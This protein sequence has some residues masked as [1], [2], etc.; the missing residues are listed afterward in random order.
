PS[1]ANLAE[2]SFAPTSAARLTDAPVRSATA[3]TDAT[4]RIR[5]PIDQV[6][7]PH[8]PQRLGSLRSGEERVK[9]ILRAEADGGG[10]RK[11]WLRLGLGDRRPS[12]VVARESR[13]VDGDA[14]DLC[15]PR[16]ESDALVELDQLRE[17]R[18]RMPWAPLD[19]GRACR[20]AEDEG[21]RRRPV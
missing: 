1:S 17:R 2:S 7:A 12:L 3:R 16:R 5:I 14:R 6:R 20:V 11:T 19:L 18:D 13:R 4:A 15:L 8:C 10:G 9:E 21:M